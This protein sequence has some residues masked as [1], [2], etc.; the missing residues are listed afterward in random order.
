MNN[1][2]N[3]VIFETGIQR[4]EFFLFVRSLM[5]LPSNRDNMSESG[6]APDMSKQP[7]LREN[8]KTIMYINR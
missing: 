4:L 1:G 2:T 3:K 6:H 8:I 5:A 7:H